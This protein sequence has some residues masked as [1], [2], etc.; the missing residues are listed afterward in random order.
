MKTEA[1]IVGVIVFSLAL[2]AT[3][4]LVGGGWE[5]CLTTQGYQLCAPR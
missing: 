4:V 2:L 3:L 5:P 1:V